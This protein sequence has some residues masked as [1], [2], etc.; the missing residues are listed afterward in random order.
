MQDARKPKRS[1]LDATRDARYVWLP[2]TWESGVPKIYW[3]D[4][5]K[6]EDYK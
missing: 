3:K 6:L 1:D 2:I 4:K 5:W